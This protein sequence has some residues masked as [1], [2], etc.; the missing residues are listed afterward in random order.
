MGIAFD[1]ACW[2]SRTIAKLNNEFR[3]LPPHPNI[4]NN[5]KK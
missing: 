4:K 5:N 1:A 3:K 2:V